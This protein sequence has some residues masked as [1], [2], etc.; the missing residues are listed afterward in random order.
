MTQLLA[1]QLPGGCASVSLGQYPQPHYAM[2]CSQPCR[3]SHALNLPLY[4]LCDTSFVGLAHD[5]VAAH[6]RPLAALCITGIPMKRSG[7]SG[8]GAVSGGGSGSSAAADA[9]LYDVRLLVCPR[10]QQAKPLPKKQQKKLKRLGAGQQQ[11]QPALGSMEHAELMHG[12]ETVMA[13]AKVSR[14]AWHIW[15]GARELLHM[16]FA[17]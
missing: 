3:S 7:S 12:A 10:R 11:H 8:S 13:W 14:T 2:L 5:M 15:G 6:F 17:Q 16:P 9:A 4:P 1:Y